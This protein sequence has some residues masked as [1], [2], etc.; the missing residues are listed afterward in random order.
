MECQ[1]TEY[2]LGMSDASCGAAP[3]F[4]ALLFKLPESGREG[5]NEAKPRVC[6]LAQ[7]TIV[8]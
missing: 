8:V 5:A 3:R 4:V 7:Y 6:V 2:T 1:Q